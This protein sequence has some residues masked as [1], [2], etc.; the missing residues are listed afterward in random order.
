MH[1]RINAYQGEEVRKLKEDLYLARRTV[2]EIVGDE[3]GRI[4]SSYHSR[5]KESEFEYES[6]GGTMV[7]RWLRSIVDDVLKLA[8]PRPMFD[9]DRALCP[10]CGGGSQSPYATGFAFPEGLRRHLL[11]EYN[12][13]KCAVMAVAGG[14]A[15]DYARRCLDHV[16]S[17][18]DHDQD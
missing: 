7:G 9:G 11:G 6:A 12:S 1:H 4:L 2:I 13:H 14:L 10:L 3:A 16:K 5:M 17:A 15:V 18:Q 8:K